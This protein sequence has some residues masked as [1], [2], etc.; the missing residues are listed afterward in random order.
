MSDFIHI[1]FLHPLKIRFNK[2][3]FFHGHLLLTKTPKHKRKYDVLSVGLFT[4][5]LLYR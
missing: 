2:L 4:T 5:D 1:K 3:H